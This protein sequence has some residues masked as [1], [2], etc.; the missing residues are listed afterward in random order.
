MS[1]I[2]FIGTAAAVASRERDNTSLFFCAGKEKILVDCPGS[3]VRKLCGCG[4]DFRKISAVFLTH[5]HPDHVYGL[6]SLIHSLSGR[7]EPV[8]VFADKRTVTLVKK[9]LSLF[10]LGK[11]D[12]PRIEYKSV[13]YGD[14]ISFSG[15]TIKILK[16]KHTPS[17]IGLKLRFRRFSAVYSGDTGP[18][19]ELIRAAGNCDYL[20]HDCFAPVRFKKEVPAL[21]GEHTSAL[22]L[23]GIAKKVS[24]G[25]LIPVHFSQE[26]RYGMQDIKR[27]IRKNY[28]GKI[29]IPADGDSLEL[30]PQRV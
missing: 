18:C 20:I 30:K 17:S 11:K 2:I 19:R 26:H 8:K 1:K 28:R 25:C 15:V 24:A 23:G 21:D 10:D 5:A 6:P 27:E 13:N 3:V 16:V 12:F 7:R 9:L 4:I 22:T 29:I 14:E